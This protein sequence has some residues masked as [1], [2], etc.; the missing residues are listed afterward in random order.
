MHSVGEMGVAC[1]TQIRHARAE[2]W[3]VILMLSVQTA[4]AQ[5]TRRELPGA[6]PAGLAAQAERMYRA[7][8]QVPGAAL[9]V[10]DWPGPAAQ[11]APGDSRAGAPGSIAGY[12][13]V[14]PQANPF[15]GEREAII[16]D[17]FCHPA[18]RARGV[19]SYLLQQAA[20]YARSQGCQ[21]LAAQ[22]ALHNQPSLRL[23][24]RAGFE[25]ERVIVGRRL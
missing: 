20:S 6:L 15:T 5:V 3:P 22:V 17:I 18:L 23:F 24:A 12:L 2:D 11:T 16:L 10:L 4:S 21:S 7:A 9:L 8:L 19:G 14:M 25:Q 13:L 1:M